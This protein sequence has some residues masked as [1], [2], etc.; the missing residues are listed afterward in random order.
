ML[1]LLQGIY[2]CNFAGTHNFAKIKYDKFLPH[3]EGELRRERRREEGGV[4]KGGK[5]EGR[6]REGRGKGEE[7]GSSHLRVFAE[8]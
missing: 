6:E 3:L 2:F 4:G 8:L 7:G 1:F 5:E